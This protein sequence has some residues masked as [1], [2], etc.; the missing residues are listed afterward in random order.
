[1]KTDKNSRTV[2]VCGVTGT[3]GNAV[4]RELLNN[5]Y[6]VRGLT[7]RTE[8]E[9]AREL[10][11]LGAQILKCDLN[12]TE[13]VTRALDGAWG[14]FG[15]FTPM[16]GGTAREEEQA[17]RFAAAAKA[18][19]LRQYVYS[20]VASADRKTG[21]PYFE[22]K[23]RV[24]RSLKDLGLKSYTVLRP[25]FFM[26]NFRSPWLWPALEKGRLTIALK[27]GTK[28]QMVAAED[29]A[30]YALLAFEKNTGLDRTAIDFAGDEMTMP[31]AAEVLGEALGRKIL[32]AELP[33]EE[34]RAASPEM[35]TMYEWFNSVGLNV[36][37]PGVA[38]KYGIKAL[39]LKQWA[40]KVKWPVAAH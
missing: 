5:G 27:P 3:Q 2:A 31:E 25:A 4:A 11:A 36:D 24:E 28:L 13:D 35:A 26:E 15:V 21:I 30:K 16:E 23:A 12:A 38:G 32:Y 10:S 37:I 1:M 17:K 6:Y 8:N 29:I 9:R 39:T 18:A 19:G 7:R 20:S 40:H 22:S 34:V 33:I 14:A